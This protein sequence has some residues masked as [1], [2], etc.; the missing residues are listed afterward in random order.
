M[1][2]YT[3]YMPVPGLWPDETQRALIEVW[4]RSW[5]KQGWN[6]VVLCEADA[7]RHPRY[8]EFKKK[9][10]EL[11]TIYGHDYCGACFMR[12]VATAVW[13]GGMMVDYDVMN[14]GF[15]PRLPE[16]DR[17][18]VIADHSVPPIFMG[19]VLGWGKYFEAMSELFLNW[20]PDERDWN[21]NGK[22]HHCDDLTFLIQCFNS[23]NRERPPW[24]EYVDGCTLF[25]KTDGLLVHYGYEMKNSGF[26]PKHEF[27][28]KIRPF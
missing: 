11:P 18:Q 27:I 9:F 24:L 25:P 14:Y 10:W 16:A 3:Y 23:N 28:E 2:V 22:F 26:W 21:P 13:G 6:P 17:M 8:A 1:N 7:A 15:A 5:A 4:K 20:V 12:W 19:A